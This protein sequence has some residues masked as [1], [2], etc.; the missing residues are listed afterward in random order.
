MVG[1][2]VDGNAARR[3][4]EGLRAGPLRGGGRVEGGPGRERVAEGEM[5]LRRGEGGRHSRRRDVLLR[6][7]VYSMRLVR[8]VRR[9]R[10]RLHLRLLDERAGCAVRGERR[11]RRAGMPPVGPIGPVR[12]RHAR[13]GLQRLRIPVARRVEPRRTSD[14][15][16]AVLRRRRRRRQ[17]VLH[18]GLA[19]G[20]GWLADER[21]GRVRRRRSEMVLNDEGRRRSRVGGG[22]R[23]KEVGEGGRGRVRAWGGRVRAASLGVVHRGEVRRLRLVWR[24]MAGRRRRVRAAAGTEV[25]LLAD[26]GRERDLELVGR[27]A[28]RLLKLMP[29]VELLVLL[30]EPPERWSGSWDSAEEEGLSSDSPRGTTTRAASPATCAW[31]GPRCASVREQL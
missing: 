21:C 22:R 8:L 25:L 18:G 6:P 24:P 14:G 11:R 28:L 3:R 17:V 20:Q 5:R 10:L 23:R 19:P 29:M 12:L 2:G 26:D 4:V 9:V 13:V 1:P 7:H 31:K 15:E 30:R 16:S 27:V